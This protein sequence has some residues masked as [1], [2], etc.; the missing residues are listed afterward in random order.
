MHPNSPAPEIAAAL[1]LVETQLTAEQVDRKIPGLSAGVVYGGELIWQRGFGYADLEKQIPAG[2]RSVYRV[3]SITKLFTATILMQ[4]RDAGKLQL[5]DPIE[6]YLPAFKL[7]S[8]FPDARPPTF[9]QVAA[10][11][12]GLPREGDHDG[13]R[14]MN[15]PS[16]EALL[17][18]L[19]QAETCFP[20]MTEP[21]YSNLGIALMGHALSLIAGR[22]YVDYVAESILRPLGMN[23]SGFDVTRYGD[24]QL[25]RGYYRDRDGQFKVAPTGTSRR[26]DPQEGCIPPSPICP[27]FIASSS[28]TVPAG[29]F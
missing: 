18:L 29:V 17:G 6:K 23:D 9:R 22:P 8:P 13:W 4:L 10:H 1:A 3:A 26:S 2:E 12:A 27:A 20:T 5:D 19:H 11:A 16:V 25:A 14:S 7:K 21:K 28:P 24:G 15:M